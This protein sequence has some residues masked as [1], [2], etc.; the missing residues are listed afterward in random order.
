MHISTA[1]L[2]AITESSHRLEGKKRKTEKN[3]KP[4]QNPKKPKEEFQEEKS[5]KVIKYR[6]TTLGQKI[7]QP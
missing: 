7:P 1:E 3:P 2:T 4:N 5:S 6:S